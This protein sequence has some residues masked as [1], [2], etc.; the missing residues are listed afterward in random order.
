MAEGHCEVPLGACNLRPLFFIFSYFLLFIFYCPGRLALPC[1]YPALPLPCPC[2]CPALPCFKFSFCCQDRRRKLHRERAVFFFSFCYQ[3]QEE[4]VTHGTTSVFFFLLLPRTG[5][6]SYTRN[7]QCFFFPFATRDRRRMGARGQRPLWSPPWVPVTFGHCFLFIIIFYSLFF[8]A[9]PCPAP[10]LPCPCPALPL[11][12]RA[13]ALPCL[14]P[15]LFRIFLLLL[16][17]GGGNY[18]GNGQCFFF[19][20]LP[21]TRGENYTENFFSF[22][23]QGREEKVTQGMGT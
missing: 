22:C 23:C 6:G 5:G 21:G 20:L 17:T 12:C 13:P 7:G 19:L 3:G 18:T 10:T 15:A 14:C 1:P 2:P 4:E 11:P 16:G 9:L 8:T